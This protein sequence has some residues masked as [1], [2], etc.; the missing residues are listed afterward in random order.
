V[1]KKGAMWDSK[2]INVLFLIY[3]LERGGPEMR[4]LDL[5]RHIPTHIKMHVCVTS[6][7]LALL[8]EFLEAGAK[9]HVEPV[10][11]GYIEFNK[12]WNIYKYAKTNHVSIINSFGLKEL[13]LS[14]AIKGMSGWKIKTVH[15]SVDL[16]HHYGILHKFFLVILFSLTDKVLCNSEK[17][18]KLVKTFFV[19]E[20]KTSLIRNGI[21]I[22]FFRKAIPQ[23]EKLRTAHGIGKSDFVLG[24]V[25]NF[26]E[27]KN[28]PFLINAFRILLQTNKNFKLICVGGGYC[29]S[30]IKRLAL[31][32]HLEKA[33]IFT[34]YS[35]HVAE[36]LSL[37]DV[38]VL[39]SLKEGFPNVLLQAMAMRRPVVS[40]DVGGCSEIIDHTKNGILYPSNDLG[41]F[42]E[43]IKMLTT[44]T[45]FSTQL[46]SNAKKT[47][48]EK[49]SLDKMIKKY[50][51]FYSKLSG[52]QNDSAA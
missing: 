32:Y 49:F 52:F 48:A 11:K 29:L 1:R 23:A 31:E 10:T 38:F 14:T 12:A 36:Y 9:I 16:L 40:A 22:D 24:T 15:H 3:D 41:K 20:R 27:V 13:F 45:K 21:D 4:L 50:A 33:I 25:A 43:S 19:S 5:Q 30:D 46:G 42:I 8:P 34:G 39:C 26:R 17:S 2:S 51:T 18:L 6:K 35:R 7:N 37:M 44:D 28:Y 47:V